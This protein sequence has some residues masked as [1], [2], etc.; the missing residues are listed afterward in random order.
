[1]KGVERNL[2]V[3]LGDCSL[4]GGRGWDHQSPTTHRGLSGTFL[5]SQQESLGGQV[6]RGQLSLASHS[7]AVPPASKAVLLPNGASSGQQESSR[8]AP[9]E[10]GWMPRGTGMNS[11]SF[12]ILAVR[13]LRVWVPK[14]LVRLWVPKN[15]PAH[16]SWDALLV[17][18]VLGMLCVCLGGFQGVQLGHW[19][20]KRAPSAQC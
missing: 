10:A 3:I 17:T 15:L 8:N 14:N 12:W 13:W 16:I 19:H 6:R 2:C 1:M 18:T 9:E 5:I 7:W 11:I 20:H 4:V